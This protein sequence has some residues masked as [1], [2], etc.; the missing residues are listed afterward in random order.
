MN[1]KSIKTHYVYVLEALH[2]N[3]RPPLSLAEDLEEIKWEKIKMSLCGGPCTTQLH[4]IKVEWSK[5]SIAI[6]TQT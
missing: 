2:D 6:N 3:L 1:T 5:P 4:P